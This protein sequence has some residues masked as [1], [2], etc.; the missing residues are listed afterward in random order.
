M[1]LRKEVLFRAWRLINLVSAGQ[2]GFSACSLRELGKAMARGLQRVAIRCKRLANCTFPP[3]YLIRPYLTVAC[4]FLRTSSVLI[5][6][7]NRVGFGTSCIT[8]SWD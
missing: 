6:I 7:G 4:D 1:F 5:P 8:C 3:N 2:T